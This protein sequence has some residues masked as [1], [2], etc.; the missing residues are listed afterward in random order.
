MLM[1]RFQ[2]E[3]RV[4]LKFWQRKLIP[5][6]GGAVYVEP[7]G[8]PGSQYPS[9]TAVECCEGENGMVRSAKVITAQ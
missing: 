6:D 9:A 7:K 5:E 4:V 8:L 2:Y 3:Q 1:D